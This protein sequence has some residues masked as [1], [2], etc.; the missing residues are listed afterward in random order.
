MNDGSGQGRTEC[1]D[2]F[3]WF[4]SAGFPIGQERIATIGCTA[5]AR[6]ARFYFCCGRMRDLQLDIFGPKKSSG[7]VTIVVDL[8]LRNTRDGRR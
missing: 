7:K 4:P 3:G 2:G 6:R 8:L 5:R 1:G